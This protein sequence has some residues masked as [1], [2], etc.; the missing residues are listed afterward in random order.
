MTVWRYCRHYTFPVLLLFHPIWQDLTLRHGWRTAAIVPELEQETKVV[1]T[2]QY[3][4]NLTWLQA[5]TGLIERM[6][7]RSQYQRCFFL[8]MILLHE[9]TGGIHH[10]GESSSCLIFFSSSQSQTNQDADSKKVLNEWQNER[11]ELRWV[12]L[13]SLHLICLWN[14]RPSFNTQTFL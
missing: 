2:S 5:L 12:Q 13:S 3:S 7:V 4:L 1:S 6:Q 10:Y 11:E 9:L 14:K 8:F